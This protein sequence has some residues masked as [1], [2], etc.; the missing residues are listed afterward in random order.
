MKSA[1]SGALAAIAVF[2]AVALVFVFSR[3]AAVE[4]VYPA[5]NA[6]KF[7][8]AKVWSRIAGAFRGAEASAENARLRRE[9]SSLSMLSDELERLDR[10]NARLRDVLG[11][12]RRTRGTYIA[13]EVLSRNGGAAGAH[14]TLRVDKGS[15]AGI[16]KGAAAVAPDGFVGRV[17]SLTPHTCEITLVTDSSLKVSCE[18]ESPSRPRPRGFTVGG[19]EK[20]LHIDYLESDNISPRARVL[21]SG[22]GGGIP[23]GILIGTYL[24]EGKVLPAVEYSL[25]KDVFIRREK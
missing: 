10:E 24:G 16:E 20:C 4:V 2:S 25:I 22:V 21:T 23:A 5:E 8:A 17:T 11:Y 15:L 19:D 12:S 14:A 1:G 9:V 3:A 6:A 18:V 7:F 13:A